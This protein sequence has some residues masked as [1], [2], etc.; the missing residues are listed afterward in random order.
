M[1]PEQASMGTVDARSDV[2]SLG[3]VLYEMLTGQLPPVEALSTLIAPPSRFTALPNGLEAVILRALATNASDR[4]QSM[5][6]FAEALAAYATSGLGNVLAELKSA[7]EMTENVDRVRT[8]VPT[9]VAGGNLPDNASEKGKREAELLRLLRN[10]R[11]EIE[12]GAF[13]QL[14]RLEAYENSYHVMFDLTRRLCLWGSRS[15]RVLKMGITDAPLWLGRENSMVDLPL[16]IESVSRQ[17][18]AFFVSDSS[19]DVED[20]STANGTFVNGKAVR[21]ETL[22]D[23]DVLHVGMSRIGV[24]ILPANRTIYSDAATPEF[25]ALQADATVVE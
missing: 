14:C 11:A 16:A 19:V 15:T 24:H 9:P 18:L 17:H 4:F 6:E 22:A 3:V 23:G 25:T 5:S 10:G 21:R 7:S 12:H 20:L 8:I 13:E 1:A 2:F